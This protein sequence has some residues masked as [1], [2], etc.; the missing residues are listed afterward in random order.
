MENIEDNY[1]LKNDQ[2]YMT[3]IEQNVS[4][5]NTSLIELCVKY[6][7]YINN[8]NDF[9][10]NN[11]SRFLIE[12]GLDT[13]IN[14]FKI[15]LLHTRNFNASYFYS[16]KAVYLYVEFIEQ[17]TKDEHKYLKLSSRDAMLYVYKKSIYELN[18]QKNIKTTNESL[19]KIKLINDYIDLF[20]LLTTKLIEHDFSNLEQM[21]TIRK[22]CLIINKF[23]NKEQYFQIYTKIIEKI[24]NQYE[25]KNI[26]L[27]FDFLLEFIFKTEKNPEKLYEYYNKLCVCETD[28]DVEHIKY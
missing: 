5:I 13:I 20:M 19:V 2:I 1:S 8:K 18:T 21:D 16:E 17:I 24:Y 15:V 22:I 12:R 26:H 11:H 6:Y 3:E 25:N 27:F 23:S 4:D 9:K 7:K 28:I 10:N 14:V